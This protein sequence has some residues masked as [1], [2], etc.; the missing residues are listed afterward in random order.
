[1]V[2]LIAHLETQL[3]T[4]IVSYNRVSGGDINEAFKIITTSREYGVKSKRSK[5]AFDMLKAECEGLEL[6]R[7][8]NKI[9]VPEVVDFGTIDSTSYLLMEHIDSRAANSRDY[10][11]L[12]K[13]LASL[14]N[15]SQDQFGLDHDNF[16]GSLPQKNPKSTSW[17]QFYLEHRLKPQLEMAADNHLLSSKEIPN[18]EYIS[19]TISALSKDVVPSLLHGDLWNGNYLIDTS[20]QPVLIDPAVYYGDRLVD[21]AMSKLFGG[22]G[23]PFYEA[24]DQHSPEITNVTEKIDLYQLYYLLV[25]LNLFG[26]SYKAAVVGCINRL[27]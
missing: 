13:Q 2:S 16:I 10:Y 20:G 5:S 19:A 23:D 6:L 12:G 21:I 3:D 1:M 15:V 14:H 22:F 11:L 26:V 25:H 4:K 27:F 8:S 7:N 17:H 18:T 9:K 24:Y